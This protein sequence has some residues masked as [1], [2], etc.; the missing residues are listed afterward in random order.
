M[1][2]FEELMTRIQRKTSNISVIGLGYIGLPTAL[3]IAMRGFNVR[4]VDTNQS[5]I[6]SLKKGVIPIH[7]IGLSE[8]AENYL[9]RIKLSSSYEGLEKT[10][11]FMLCLPSPITEDGVP[12]IRY[13]EHAVKSIAKCTEAGC[14][15]LVES[16]VPV[17]TT[18]YLALLFERESNLQP[19]NQFWFAHCP[20]RVLP[21]KLIEEID[22]NHRLVGGISNKSTNL[23]LAFLSQIFTPE[24]LHPTLA[25]VSEVTK[26]VENAYRDVNIAY[27]NEIAKLCSSFSIDVFEVIRLANLHPRVSILRPGLGVGGYCLPKDGW[28]FVESARKRGETAELIPAARNVNNSMPSYV[29]NKIREEVLKNSKEGRVGLLGI[30]FKENVSDTRNS[31][32]IELIRALV[33]TDIDTLVYDPFVNESFGAKSIATIRRLIELADYIVLCVGHDEIIKE[34]QKFNLSN[35]I[36]FDPSGLMPNLRNLV[37]K[38]I[39]LSV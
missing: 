38:Y 1:G 17:G 20:E 35:K 27:A 15:V 32:T 4:G 22:K 21:G 31:P 2:L 14:L 3:F 30:S 8:I 19:D 12:V 24:L 36:F 16:T 23:A 13:L 5:M 34:L 33:S 25:S 10:D 26:L 7:E 18:E 39:G 6:E 28:I 37:K 9:S 29:S 11:V